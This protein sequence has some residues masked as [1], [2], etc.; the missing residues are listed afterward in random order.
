MNYK[1]LIDQLAEKTGLPKSKTKERLEDVVS[2]LSEQLSDGK[3]VSIP[4]LG[5]F[6]AIEKKPKKVYNPHHKAYLITA[7]KRVVEFSPSAHLKKEL[8]FTGGGNE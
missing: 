4:D 5:T 8:K 3:G 2:V 7:P 6:T 1:D